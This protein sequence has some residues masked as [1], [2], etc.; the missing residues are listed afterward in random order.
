MPL[1]DTINQTLNDAVKA[2]DLSLATTL[3]TVKSALQNAAI[4]NRGELNDK[5]VIEV[6]QKEA[7]KRRE[8]IKLYE[9]SGR[10]ELTA[11]ERKE[12]KVIEQYLPPSMSAA[13][14]EK[15]V[16]DAI[17]EVG[18][19]NMSG[20]GAVMKKVAELGK[21]RIDGGEAARLVREK[22]DKK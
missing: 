9:Q 18:A 14:I 1:T 7:R 6:L 10:S 15:V 16:A 8:A 5:Q 11:Q 21:G 19:T 20:M 12:I 3:R 13:E 17:S 22:L 2:K 4:D